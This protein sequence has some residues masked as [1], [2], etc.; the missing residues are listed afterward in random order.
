[1][2][3]RSEVPRER[4]VGAEH[5][6]R[7]LMLR[8]IHWHLSAQRYL[9]RSGRTHQSISCLQVGQHSGSE[10]ASTLEPSP[11]SVESD[12]QIELAEPRG[13]WKWPSFVIRSW[14]SSRASR[15]LSSSKSYSSLG[16]GISIPRCITIGVSFERSR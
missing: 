9:W 7:W 4:L 10:A 3:D 2:G 6:S 15:T 8:M 14:R 11:E 12:V 5:P 1:M 16:C 13:R